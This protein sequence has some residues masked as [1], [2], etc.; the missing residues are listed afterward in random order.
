LSVA[1]LDARPQ[2]KQ[3]L[4]AVIEQLKPDI[5]ALQEIKDRQALEQLSF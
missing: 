2:R 4:K 3:R 5:V 1:D